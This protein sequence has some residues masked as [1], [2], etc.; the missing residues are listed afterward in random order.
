[1]NRLRRRYIP[2]DLLTNFPV[3]DDLSMTLSRLTRC[4]DREI[5]NPFHHA[6]HTC[7]PTQIKSSI[8]D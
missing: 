3:N 8:T 4:I 1:M 6:Q 5:R 2:M 7:F